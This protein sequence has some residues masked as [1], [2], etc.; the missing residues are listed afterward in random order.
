MLD[1]QDMVGRKR[2][3][4]WIKPSD[5]DLGKRYREDY[6]DIDDLVE[7]IKERGIIQ[8]I[9][10]LRKAEL[11]D[12]ELEELGESDQDRP[13]LLMAGGRRTTAAIRADL[14]TVPAQIYNHALD[15]LELRI[16]ELHENL[17]RKSLSFVEDVKLKAE[18][19]RLQVEKYGEKVSTAV[20][21]PGASLATTAEFLGVSKATM[22]ND[23]RLSQALEEYPELAG[24]DS[25]AEAWKQYD[26]IVKKMAM[27]I[28]AM[29]QRAASNNN[30][31]STNNPHNIRRAVCS[32]YQVGSFFEGV[33]QVPDGTI[34]LVEIDPPYAVDLKNI[35][36]AGDTDDY[37]EIAPHFYESFMKSTFAEAYRVTKDHAWMICWFGPEWFEKIFCWIEAAGKPEAM[38]I[39]DWRTSK[40]GFQVRR[41]PGIWMKRNG[42]TQQPD[43]YLASA[44]EYFFYARKGDPGIAK[45]GR[46]NIFDFG[47]VAPQRKRHPT[48]RPIEMLESLLETFAR[49]RE[50]IL[51]PFAGS[52][53]TILAANNLGMP[54]IG[55]D[56]SQPYKDSFDVT[57]MTN[58]KDTFKSYS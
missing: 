41:M 21:A 9:A 34:K 39:E 2:E 43:K 38:S 26:G 23:V 45:Q 51:V 54:C 13:Y 28:L 53:N 12:E 14:E 46:S 29:R 16:I 20:D 24:A 37:N 47:P 42:Q 32:L 35:K 44:A 55:W 11:T 7:D 33:K 4:D 15:H 3:L 50:T 22:S 1:T 19:H 25:K 8:P 58:E 52:G 30:P 31:T 5:I 27:E 40:R 49:T 36:K 6:E 56:L 48:E 17:H 10:V 57:V 18:I